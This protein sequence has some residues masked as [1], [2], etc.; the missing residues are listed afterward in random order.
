MKV[1]S[2]PATVGSDESFDRGAAVGDDASVHGTACPMYFGTAGRELFGILHPGAEATGSRRMA[3]LLCSPFGLEAIRAQRTFR[4]L[5]ER[6]ARAG[7]VVLRFDYYG[8][9]DSAGEDTEVTLAGWREDIEVASRRL[10]A[11]AP[12][13]PMV[14]IGLGLGATAALQTA[15]HSASPPSRLLLWEPIV[16]GRAYLEGLRRRHAAVVETELLSVR[17]RPAAHGFEALGFAISPRFKSEIEAITA[18]GLVVRPGLRTTLV[19][20]PDN[21]HAKMFVECCKSCV[22]PLDYVE[23]SHTVDWMSETADAGTLVPGPVI[24]KLAAQVRN[25]A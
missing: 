19:T 13:L 25:S 1:L 22:P 10:Q 11:A 3:V 6:L 9:G 21:L 20:Q 2:S 4:V 12:G 17:L 24:L 18:H 8:S 23:Q 15:Q 5:A 14:W 7:H 16:D